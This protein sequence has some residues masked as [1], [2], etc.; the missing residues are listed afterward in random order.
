MST[1]NLHPT[2]APQVWHIPGLARIGAFLSLMADTFAE[3]Q[4]SM[5]EAGKKYPFAG[6]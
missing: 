6:L 5:R 2:Q 1:L 4:Q 3:A